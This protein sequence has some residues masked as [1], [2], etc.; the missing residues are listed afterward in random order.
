MP[1]P[2]AGAVGR[3]ALRLGLTS[4]GGPIAHLGFFRTEYV[5][6]QRALT[7]AQYGEAVA[8]AQF[9]PGPGSSQVG[10]A[11][12]Y[13]CA[14]W[15]GA[16]AA[17]AGFTLPSAVMMA[18]LGAVAVSSDIGG[19]GLV[20]GLKVVAVAVVADAIV[21]MARSLTT[22]IG[23]VAL[24][25]AAAL[26]ALRLAGHPAGQVIIIAAAA[27]LG[28]LLL[29][30]RGAEAPEAGL[31]APSRR[32]GAFLL[33]IFALLLLSLP[34]LERTGALGSLVAAHYRA[35][36]LVFGGGHVVLPLLE[37][38]LVPEVVPETTFLAGYG[39]AQAVP[40]PLFTFGTYLGMVGGGV[41]GAVL[42]TI[43]IFLPGAL[44]LFGVL[45]FWSRV[46]AS[47][48]ARSALAGV[49]AAV[50]GIL[51]AAWIDPIVT[52]SITSV[53]AAALALGLF[54]LLRLAR[55]PPWSLVLLGAVAGSLLL[56]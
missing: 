53:G 48:A 24:A 2:T 30:G 15:R 56:G 28:W 46:S 55:V 34:V 45:P 4:F 37:A 31:R 40:G 27:L 17:W 13:Q 39:A 11:V 54:G 16:L 9:L 8:V 52:D 18:V 49:N 14:G 38:P 22:S 47:R 3:T 42:A 25:V 50:V 20:L 44:L 19:S 7:D 32:T 43:A 10:M 23:T 5:Q 21:G 6:R 26:A 41:L 12:G 35:G 51:T 1:L 29:R 33:G 36:S